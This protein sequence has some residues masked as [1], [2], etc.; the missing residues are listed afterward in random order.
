[1]SDAPLE[2]RINA[3][4][5]LQHLADKLY[6]DPTAALRAIRQHAHAEG[7]EAVRLKLEQDF[8]A[9]GEPGALVQGPAR[10]R[11][12]GVFREGGLAA[13]MEKW[14]ALDHPPRPPLVA[15][16]TQIES[17]LH[18]PNAEQ[19]G[20]HSPDAERVPSPGERLNAEEQLAYDQLKAYAEALERADR[21]QEAEAQLHAI[22]DHRAHLAAAESSLPTAKASLRDEV[23]GTY[24]DGGKA[25]EQIEAAMRQDGPAETARRIRS[26]ELLAREQR[27]AVGRTRAFGLIPRRDRPAEG[28]ARE[29]VAKRIETI[30]FYEGDLGKWSTFTP[31]DGPAV[32]G[33]KNVRAALDREE[34]RVLAYSDMGPVRREVET[35]RAPAPHPTREA[36]QLGHSAQQH[37]DSLSR[38]SRERVT[39]AASYAG[40]DKM[41]AALGHLQTIQAA[42]RTLREGMEG[43]GH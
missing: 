3:R 15:A 16:D 26:G 41:T 8:A 31:Q 33:A 34:A 38:A 29:R 1:M 42:A 2:Q 25:M 24:R 28:D 17:G 14:L 37:L 4:A 30:G 40:G 39:R 7:P 19:S 23:A 9:F 35:R 18:S 43:P 12:Q 6:A 21:R 5:Q 36:S 10:D 20:R 22:H 13:Q 27:H 11:A 32:R